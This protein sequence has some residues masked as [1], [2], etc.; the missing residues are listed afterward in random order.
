MINVER[1]V[2]VDVNIFAN[3]IREHSFQKLTNVF[4]LK[5]L[6]KNVYFI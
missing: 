2:D 3:L 6:I 5:V 4:V 1:N